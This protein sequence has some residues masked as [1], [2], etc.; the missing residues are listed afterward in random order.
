MSVKYNSEAKR[1]LNVTVMQKNLATSNHLIAS[2]ISTEAKNKYIPVVSGK[3]RRSTI[4]GIPSNNISIKNT[5]DYSEFVWDHAKEFW[6]RQWFL[7]I[8]N[9]K[10]N[11]K[12]WEQLIIKRW[13]GGK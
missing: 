9:V 1:L 6:R 11:I 12:R 10:R 2:D 4:V 8:V 13:R 7:K 3:L 5:M